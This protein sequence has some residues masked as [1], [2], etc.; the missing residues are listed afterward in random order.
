MLFEK[1]KKQKR[2]KK[3][4]GNLEI[5]VEETARDFLTKLSEKVKQQLNEEL[6]RIG[7]ESS[8]DITLQPEGEAADLK[9]FQI[10]VIVPEPDQAIKKEMI[11]A[12]GTAT[13]R[14][15]YKGQLI[16]LLINATTMKSHQEWQIANP[17]EF[18]SLFAPLLKCEVCGKEIKSR[19][20]KE[21]YGRNW[22]LVPKN[23]G[24]KVLIIKF[25]PNLSTERILNEIFEKRKNKRIIKTVSELEELNT[26]FR[27]LCERAKNAYS[28][29]RDFLRE[30]CYYIPTLDPKCFSCPV[31]QDS[32]KA[33]KTL[34]EL[35]NFPP[36]QDL[37]EIELFEYLGK[38]TI[39][40][41]F[42]E[43]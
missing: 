2:S 30:K 42:K 8:E 35:S 11:S 7:F 12:K 3:M 41:E 37:K 31:C 5:N 6:E 29:L 15:E 19:Y 1:R 25:S 23:S 27:K 32:L 17:E 24:N 38:T 26:E 18:L 16:T 20:I 21:R 4:R 28:S 33:V 43:A 36:F 10:L 14:Y 40:I 34:T 39:S 22:R 9:E 13:L